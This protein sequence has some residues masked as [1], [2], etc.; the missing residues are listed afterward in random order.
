MIPSVPFSLLS[1]LALGLLFAWA[2]R[3]QFR[4]GRAPWGREMHAVASYQILIRWPLLAYFFLAHRE[5]SLL[6]TVPA[7]HLWAALL[8]VLLPLDAAA[9]AGGYVGGW[10]LLRR[11]GCGI[12]HR[13]CLYVR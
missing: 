12:L 7:A 3:S 4:D 9:L 8:L 6:Y 5:W 1:G 10:A 11:R 13:G 2:A